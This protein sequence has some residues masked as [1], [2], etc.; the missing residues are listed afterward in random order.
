MEGYDR[1][2]AD[3]GPRG[4]TVCPSQALSYVPPP[5]IAA[6]RRERPVDLF[7]FGNQSVKTKVFMMMPPGH[8][9]ATVDVVDYMWEAHEDGNAGWLISETFME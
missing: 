1:T 3:L 8:M 5:K 2:S 9:A 7:V 6:D 4:A